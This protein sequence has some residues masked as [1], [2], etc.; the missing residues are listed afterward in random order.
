MP[1]T[2][3][4]ESVDKIATQFQKE[5]EAEQKLLESMTESEKIGYL[6]AKSSFNQSL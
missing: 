5:F 6:A 1:N 3:S 2:I 4:K